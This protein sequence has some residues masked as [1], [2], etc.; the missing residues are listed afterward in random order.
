MIV[1]FGDLVL[2]FSESVCIHVAVG[3]DMA[4]DSRVNVDVNV[5]VFVD[6]DIEA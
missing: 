1:Y 2:D 6:V 5:P 3:I 4:E